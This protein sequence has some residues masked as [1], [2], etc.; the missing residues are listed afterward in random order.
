LDCWEALNLKNFKVN[1]RGQFTIIA[2][3]LVAVILVAAVITTYSSIRYSNLQDQPQT[4]S[5]IDEVNLALKKI[6]GFTV[7]YYGSVLQVTG[8]NSY[9]KI[10]ASKYLSSGL[11]NIADIRPEWAPSFNVSSL[12]LKTNWFTNTSFSSGNFTIKYDLGGIGVYSMTYSASSRLDA[13]ILQSSSANQAAL[14]ITSDLEPLVDLGFKNFKFYKYVFSN[15]TWEFVPPS[16]EPTMFMNGV[17]LIDLPA[18]MNSSYLIEVEDT[19]GLMVVASSFSR[20]TSALTWNTTS[21]EEGFDYVD[22]ANAN[23][24]GTHGNFS[25]QQSPPD[26]RRSFRSRQ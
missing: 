8:N 15:S 19:R 14:N 3:L 17:Y 16:S 9:A 7:G 6:L 21:V 1:K 22:Y 23:I 24:T 11:D 12:D 26:N 2:A 20:F 25:A 10:L 4:L 13:Q 5:A 18:G